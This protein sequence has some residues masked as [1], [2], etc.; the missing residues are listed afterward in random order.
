MVKN[1]IKRVLTNWH[2]CPN[3]SNSYSPKWC[4]NRITRYNVL[5]LLIHVKTDAAG[6][7][8]NRWVVMRWNGM[9][10][11]WTPYEE[12]GRFCSWNQNLSVLAQWTLLSRILWRNENH[13]GLWP[14][15][16]ILNS[17]HWWRATPPTRGLHRF[18][19]NN[20]A[21]PEHAT[22]RLR[23]WIIGLS[24][25]KGS[26]GDPQTQTRRFI[27]TELTDQFLLFIDE[28]PFTVLRLGSFIRSFCLLPHQLSLATTKEQ[29][30]RCN[31]LPRNRDKPQKTN[32]QKACTNISNQ[33]TDKTVIPEIASNK[34][35][36]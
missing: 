28:P 12:W 16:Q 7:I 35:K 33:T 25:A 8:R 31:G 15:L 36:A 17:T 26:N 30:A 1:F 23:D 20:G 18:P 4:L 14:I 34:F 19:L 6:G 22:T 21:I 27:S 32:Q 13:T 9:Q 24:P 2:D 11:V 29:L 10:L 5:L 3:F